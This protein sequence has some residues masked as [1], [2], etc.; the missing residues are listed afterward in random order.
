MLLIVKGKDRVAIVHIDDGRDIL[1]KAKAA[2]EVLGPFRVTC[3]NSG[4]SALK[5]LQS[6]FPELILLDLSMP[7]MDGRETFRNIRKIAVLE[8]VPIVF[9]TAV[10]SPEAQQ[11]LMELGATDVISKPFDPILLHVEI[12]KHI[13]SI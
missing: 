11:E 9:L 7:E 10:N 1:A 2:L 8:S 5:E 12:S 6:I 13:S 4:K 3:F